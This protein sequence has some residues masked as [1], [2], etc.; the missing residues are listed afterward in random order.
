[1][2]ESGKGFMYNFILSAT[3]EVNINFNEVW[4]VS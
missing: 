4:W 2:K 1:L 3:C